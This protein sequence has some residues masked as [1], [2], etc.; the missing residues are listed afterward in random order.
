MCSFTDRAGFITKGSIKPFQLIKSWRRHDRQHVCS[1]H[2]AVCFSRQY[3]S[4]WLNIFWGGEALSHCFT[5][6]NFQHNSHYGSFYVIMHTCK[7]NCTESFS[8]IFILNVILCPI[9]LWHIN[10][11]LLNSPVLVY[12]NLLKYTVFMPLWKLLSSGVSWPCK[13][14]CG[15]VSIYNLDL[16]NTSFTWEAVCIL[17]FN[18]HCYLFMFYVFWKKMISNKIE[19]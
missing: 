7:E 9:S 18:P 11:A 2:P 1:S 15:C 19:G 14:R 3:I 4:S 10:A 8:Y 5:F 17:N 16:P 6:C 13:I 12:K